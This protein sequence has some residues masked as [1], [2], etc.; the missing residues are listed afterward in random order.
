MIFLT[1]A[2]PPSPFAEWLRVRLHG[3][4]V[5]VLWRWDHR[6]AASTI[7]CRWY[8]AFKCLCLTRFRQ[9]GRHADAVEGLEFSVDLAEVHFAVA[10]S[11][12]VHLFHEFFTLHRDQ[13]HGP[14]T[15]VLIQL[16][17]DQG[18]GIVFGASD[19]GAEHVHCLMPAGSDV[20][21][22]HCRFPG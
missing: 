9:K 19:A 8:R 6:Q 15:G 13:T 1:H 3:I 7:G 10:C 16:V 21:D 11:P 12:V 4:V 2:I 22:V 20:F 14:A 17:E 18:R 5:V